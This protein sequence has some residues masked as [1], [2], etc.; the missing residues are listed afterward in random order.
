VEFRLDFFCRIGMEV[1][2]ALHQER[3]MRPFL[4]DS[5]CFSS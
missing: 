4:L 2:V 5:D 3:K 1:G